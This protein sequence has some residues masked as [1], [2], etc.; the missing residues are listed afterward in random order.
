[1]SKL[2]DILQEEALQEV[3]AI[4]AEA[5]SKAETL[6]REAK[7]AASG[8]VAARRKRDDAELRVA[9]RRAKSTAE[10]VLSAA[11]MNTKGQV[12]DL[13]T[14]KALAGLDA[15]AAMPNYG[16]VLEAL[17]EEA[18]AAVDG[19]EVL[20]A[21]P[22]DQDK[23]RSWAMKKGLDLTTDSSLRLGVKIVGRGGR[24][25][26]ENSLPGRLH[27]AW[28]TLASGVAERLWE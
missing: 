10:L 5:D 22:D 3:N 12:I 18:M 14:E 16:E 17:A 19:A 15:F 24:R 21:H 1:M 6:I 28:E 7:E 11:R 25:S 20:V 26:V 2:R 8:R 13:V 4:L 23:L 9:A 27:R